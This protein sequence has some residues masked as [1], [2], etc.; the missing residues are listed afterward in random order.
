MAPPGPNPSSWEEGI[1]GEGIP[2]GVSFW[3][4][5]NAAVVVKVLG[6]KGRRSESGRIYV[7]GIREFLWRDAGAAVRRTRAVSTTKP[8]STFFFRILI[9]S[10]SILPI[11]KSMF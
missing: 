5:R 1:W 2:V 8:N 3:E 7:G 4:Q 6:E 11:L 10:S 9:F